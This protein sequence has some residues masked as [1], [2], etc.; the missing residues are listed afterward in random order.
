MEGI[1]RQAGGWKYPLVPLS[2]VAQLKRERAPVQEGSPL[3][4]PASGKGPRG[5]TRFLARKGEL[6]V[7]GVNPQIAFICS[8]ETCCLTR[9]YFTITPA[10]GRVLPQ[11]LQVLFASGALADQTALLATG[12]KKKVL[13]LKG[14]R[15]LQV[16]LPPLGEQERLVERWEEA[17]RREREKTR[18]QAELDRL[19]ASFSPADPSGGGEVLP[20]GRVARAKGGI[21]F[22]QRQAR[23]E[24]AP[25]YGSA[26]ITGRYFK[27]RP[28]GYRLSAKR[29][30]LLG[31]GEVLVCAAG[32]GSLG[33]A[34]VYPGGP[35]L[36]NRSVVRLL[37]DRSL[38]DPYYL[39]LYC[40]SGRFAAKAQAAAR[41]AGIKYLSPRAV[42]KMPLVLPPLPEQERQS[43]DY[44]ERALHLARLERTWE[45]PRTFA[46]RLVQEFLQR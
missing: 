11:Y 36:V 44:R 39:A 29:S 9:D 22:R 24:G 26:T 13:G 28:L 45:D 16:P 7:Q 20:L 42:E 17:L 23:E 15:D 33:R 38:V 31:E 8:R 2:Q 21:T 1:S 10:P 46:G 14:A 3:P 27:D 43:R 4:A 40:N 35:G 25:V 34:A 19:C 37:P 41:G 5:G 6:C 18:L 32:E 12:R 30:A